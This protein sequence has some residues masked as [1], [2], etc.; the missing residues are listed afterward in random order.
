MTGSHA[1][2]SWARAQSKRCPRCR[3]AVVAHPGEC[4]HRPLPSHCLTRA[5]AIGLYFYLRPSSIYNAKAASVWIAKLCGVT[6]AGC[7]TFLLPPVTKTLTDN[8]R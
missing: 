4:P 6:A 2:T 3:A 1:G 7:S 5:A 8:L